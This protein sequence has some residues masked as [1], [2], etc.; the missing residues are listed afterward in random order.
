VAAAP[1]I[2]YSN[3]GP[4][5]SFDNVYGWKLQDSIREPGYESPLWGV[6]QRFTPTADYTFTNAQFPIA[7]PFGESAFLPVLLQA[8]AGGIPGAIIEELA[9][10]G[11]SDWVASI[12]TVNS[13]SE[14][15]LKMGTHYWLT[16]M[17]VYAGYGLWSLNSI[18]DVS[19]GTFASTHAGPAGP[20][21]LGPANAQIISLDGVCFNPPNECEPPTSLRSAFQINGRPLTAQDI[22]GRLM[23]DVYALATGGSLKP[24]QAAGLVSKLT[25]AMERLDRGNSTSACNQLAAF[26][27][28]VNALMKAGT[29]TTGAAQ[30]LIDT[31]L[32]AAT[33]AG[34]DG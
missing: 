5:M 8:D 7:M 15:I 16:V 14:P 22:I 32:R 11:Q 3:F 28:H 21:V 19:A 20:W 6:S 34:C 4:G 18:G 25:A 1:V 26:V 33:H 10:F 9:Q 23:D 24:G 13:V 29:L 2:V 27:N 17:P 31:A 30:D 12:V